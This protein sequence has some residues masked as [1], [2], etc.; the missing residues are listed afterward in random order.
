MCLITKMQELMQ[1]I[2]IN[3]YPN[4]LL[5]FEYLIRANQ[6]FVSALIFAD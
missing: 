5:V 3:V 4:T 2:Y 6:V 1:K